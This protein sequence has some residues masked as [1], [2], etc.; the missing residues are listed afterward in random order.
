MGFFTNEY[1]SDCTWMT[2]NEVGNGKFACESECP[3]KEVYADKSAG[4]CSRFTSAMR[5]SSRRKEELYNISR[6]SHYIITAISDILN[7]GDDNKYHAAFE[8][9]RDVYIPVIGEEG[10]IFMEEYNELGTICAEKLKNDEDNETYAEYLRSTYLD[11]FA[12]LIKI[13]NNQAA[14]EVYNQMFATVKEKYSL[15]WDVKKLLLTN[16]DNK[17]SE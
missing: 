1:C 6:R 14:F 7:L 13:N 16:P 8:Y 2:E 12:S 10:Q 17:K 4:D 5:R 3:H 11:N 9:M 15:K